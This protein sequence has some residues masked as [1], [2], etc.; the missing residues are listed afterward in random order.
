[1]IISCAAT[2]IHFLVAGDVVQIFHLN[3]QVYMIA[4]SVAIFSTV[5][6]SFMMSHVIERIGASS[7]S[8]ISSIGPIWVLVLAYFV[9]GESFNTTQIAG[10]LIV[11]LG[12]T[13]I[14]KKKKTS[15]IGRK[16]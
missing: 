1:M 4:L 15:E 9:L 14:T 5:L 16:K 8:I 6:P 7:T 3:W 11:I 12:I 10:T 13:L 2:V